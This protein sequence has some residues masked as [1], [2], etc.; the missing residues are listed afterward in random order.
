MSEIPK[1]GSAP[2]SSADMSFPSDEDQESSGPAQNQAAPS[3]PTLEGEYQTVV[4]ELLDVW[5]ASCEAGDPVE[6]QTLCKDHPDLVAEIR[7]RVAA[8]Q[9]VDQQLASRKKDRLHV[10]PVQIESVIDRLQFVSAGGLG[11]VFVG[12]DSRL[13]R[14]VAIKF[15]HSRLC[16]DQE[17]RNRFALEAEVTGRLEHPGVVPLYG[18]GRTDDDRMFYAMRFIDGETLDDAI[19]RYFA[20]VDHPDERK[21]EA[22]ELGVEFRRL[23]SNFVSV[24]KTIAYAHNR[25]IV[26]RDIK[27]ANVMLGRFGE[28][29][30]VDW[31]L[32]V[33]VLRDER[34]KCSGEKTLMPSSSSASGSSS[35]R[36]AG[37]PAFMSPEQAS[38]L[39]P[40]PA[41]DIYSLG[42]TLFKILSG[43]PPVKS[44]SIAQ[45]RHDL[46][47]GKLPDL[48]E[49]RPG[50][51][52]SLQAIAYKA[53]SRDAKDRYPTASDL[54]ADVERYL[55]DEP[56]TAA[57]DSLSVRIARVAR[58]H[59]SAAQ[60]AVLGLC[61][62]FLIA[63]I[64]AVIL[65]GVANRAHRLQNQ[66]LITSSQLVA[67]SLSLEVD[68]I[69]RV[70]ESVAVSSELKSLVAVAN[71][72]ESE[73][74]I[75]LDNQVELQQWL[76]KQ[77]G[78]KQ[79]RILD[80]LVVL[81]QRGTQLARSP[82]PEEPQVGMNFAYRDYFTGL[83]FDL[84]PDS[85]MARNIEPL[86]GPAVQ[87]TGVHMSPAYRSTQADEQQLK[88]TLS[89]PILG[90]DGTTH[91][92]VVGTS[93][94]VGQ[95][96]RELLGD[97]DIWLVDMRDTMTD[98]KRHRGILLTHPDMTKQKA[99]SVVPRLHNDTVEE[100]LAR[101]AAL[102]DSNM[103][104]DQIMDIQDPVRQTKVR[105]A[106]QPIVIK[107]P[108]VG[109][110]NVGW[111][112]VA[113]EDVQ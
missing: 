51:S 70:L 109:L 13:H 22:G 7:R 39:A 16:A 30:V 68:R 26:H 67:R 77:L 83:G 37:T 24:C 87:P 25:G 113:A 73:Q 71:R 28:T 85:R 49:I 52:K 78:N 86:A 94:D 6:V 14:R 97:L 33:S 1:P 3:R 34:F 5:E 21:H 74:A 8:L 112:V 4:D 64:S 81:G 72:L 50:I 40:T 89:V 35:G 88:V 20:K 2:D 98:G 65:G 45:I 76:D 53:M 48:N 41:S 56:V 107:D 75:S 55:A 46:I 57:T 93:L 58:K 32:A 95:M 84:E 19:D 66:N 105:A 42:A 9:E 90:E 92:G 10:D 11:E 23:L 91:I 36:G 102:D 54:A 96:M 18:F 38:D 47:D 44:K 108:E 62:C 111:A 106:V 100:L 12:E 61:G 110:L 104:S 69:W 15:M 29:I 80:R 99:L 17:G 63:G 101:F 79:V 103:Y 31:G 60:T 82:M 43:K 59:R 27:P